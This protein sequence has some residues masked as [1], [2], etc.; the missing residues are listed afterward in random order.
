MAGPATALITGVGGQ[1]GVYLARELVSHGY[2][3]VGTLQPGSESSRRSALPYLDG[4][5]V[6]ELDLRDAAGFE[7]LL[8]EFRPDEIYNLAAFSSVGASWDNREHVAEVNGMAVLRMLDS[9]LRHR[10]RHGSCARFYQASTSEMFGLSK[11]QPQTEDTPHYPRSPYAVAKSFAHYLTINYRE[12]YDLY[13]CS[14][15]LYNHESPLRGRQFVTRK[16]TRAAAE[17]ACGVRDRVSL[18]NLAVER[19]WGAASDYVSAMRLLL[20]HDEPGDYIIAT[21]ES[22]SLEQLLE[23]AFESAGL[24][25]PWRYVDQDPALIRPTDVGGLIG[26]A[27]KARRQLGWEPTVRFEQVVEEMVQ[28]DIRRVQSGVEESADYLVATSS[29]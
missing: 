28:V 1:D 10:D 16:I 21:G 26:D 6:R 13:C 17:I 3:V 7:A 27:G 14:G 15:I 18:G 22:H 8:E 20:Q 19:D 4:V 25:D 23:V 11:E 24:G 5:V 29:L 9:L 2:H 12:S